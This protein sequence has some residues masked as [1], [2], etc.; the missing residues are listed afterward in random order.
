MDSSLSGEDSDDLQPEVKKV[1][2]EVKN[3]VNRR[4]D[5]QRQRRSRLS[6]RDVVSHQ[7]KGF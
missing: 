1:K 6:S 2:H 3:T 7:P 5:R 4:Y